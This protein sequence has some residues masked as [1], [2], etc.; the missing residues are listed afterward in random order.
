MASLVLK[1]IREPLIKTL[2]ELTDSENFNCKAERGV[3]STLEYQV[4]ARQ[5]W[6]TW[7]VDRQSLLIDSVMKNQVITC[8]TM[9][10]IELPDEK[11]HKQFKIRLVLDG[12]S[13]LNAA[14]R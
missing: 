12:Q 8:M 11:T 14:Q 13:R 5:R 10:E 9:S 4:A 3:F 6:S 2:G 7:D 1:V